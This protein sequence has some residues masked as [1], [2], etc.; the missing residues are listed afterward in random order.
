VGETVAIY[1]TGLGPVTPAIVAGA[2]GPVNPL[3]TVPASTE[4]QIY[5]DGVE[6]RVLYQGL[7][8]NLS[9]LYQINATIPPGVTLGKS[10]G[11]SIGTLDAYNDMA[12]IPIAK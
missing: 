9:G 11:V 4:V 12:T 8:P 7:A 6:A 5:F 1:L 2:L 3:S 10:V